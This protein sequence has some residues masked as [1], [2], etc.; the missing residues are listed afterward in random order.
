MHPS[1]SWSLEISVDQEDATA[2]SGHFIRHGD[3]MDRASH[4]T[5]ERMKRNQLYIAWKSGV[6]RTLQR[7]RQLRCDV[8]FSQERDTARFSGTVRFDA[9]NNGRAGEACLPGIVKP[10]LECAVMPLGRTRPERLVEPA[11]DFFGT[12]SR[13][14]DQFDAVPPAIRCAEPTGPSTRGCQESQVLVNVHPG[15]QML[16]RVQSL[17]ISQF[18]HD[19]YS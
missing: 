18:G 13:G 10:E 12:R 1:N 16:R 17:Q 9:E 4:S 2:A 15:E 5:L 6:G 3:C 19:S 8:L 11:L 14:Y 7:M